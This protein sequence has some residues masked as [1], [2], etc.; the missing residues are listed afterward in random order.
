MKKLQTI[1]MLLVFCLAFTSFKNAKKVTKQ[2]KLSKIYCQYYSGNFA[3]ASIDF[4]F[5]TA[6][7]GALNS[8]ITLAPLDT[9]AGDFYY[10]D[11]DGLDLYIVVSNYHGPFT[12]NFWDDYAIGGP[13]NL[14]TFS[15]PVT[16]NGTY[17][18][19]TNYTAIAK[20]T[21]DP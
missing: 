1:S 17:P 2:G 14:P 16:G 4:Y 12:V 9:D 5:E 11:A 8:Q 6:G 18:F 7:G 13:S 21:C 3:D 19:S 15:I 10:D 20:I